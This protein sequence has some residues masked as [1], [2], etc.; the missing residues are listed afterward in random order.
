[1][2]CTTEHTDKQI[3]CIYSSEYKSIID[4][5]TGNITFYKN[6]VAVLSEKGISF[7]RLTELQKIYSEKANKT[8]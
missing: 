3:I 5:A 2:D 7:D 8:S 1:M 6:E 4:K